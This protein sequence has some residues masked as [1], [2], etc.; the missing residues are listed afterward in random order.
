VA[1]CRPGGVRKPRARAD[2]RLRPGGSRGTSRCLIRLGRPCN[3]PASRSPWTFAAA[4]PTSPCGPGGDEITSRRPELDRAT[5]AVRKL[6]LRHADAL[7]RGDETIVPFV[8]ELF[9]L[10]AGLRDRIEAVLG[11]RRLLRG[12][13]DT[14]W[15]FAAHITRNLVERGDEALAPEA[16]GEIVEASARLDGHGW[17]LR[18]LRSRA[19]ADATVEI[20]TNTSKRLPGCALEQLRDNLEVADELFE[21]G[22]T[23][24]V[25]LLTQD[26]GRMHG[27][28]HIRGEV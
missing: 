4:R 21:C 10:R 16:V 24:L 19:R 18:A 2:R 23:V 1:K 11:Q 13:P 22:C 8:A 15:N 26:R 6:L 20:S 27:G 14:D 28:N 9:L 12:D 25:S 17:L 3:T 7:L 5:R